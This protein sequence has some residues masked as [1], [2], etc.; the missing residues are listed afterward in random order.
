MSPEWGQV[1]PFAL[2]VDDLTIYQRGEFEY[3]VYLDP[4][5]PP[6][7]GGIGDAD[8]RSGFEQVVEW[9]GQLDPADGVMIDISPNSRGNNTLGTNDG[10]GREINPVT[11]L[12]YTQQI[13]P[14]GDY[15]RVLAEFWAD[16]PDSETPPGHWFTIA[17]YV[18]D[19][20]LVVRRFGGVGEPLDD[21]E[22]DVKLYF[23]LGGT[24]HDAAVAA[25]GAKGWYDYI[26]PISAIR[27][28]AVN[29]QSSDP[30][31]PSYHPDGIG[32]KPGVIEVVTPDTVASGERHEHLVGPGSENLGKIAIKA[33]R[34]P[35]FISDPAT[36]A[37]GVGWI[38][39]ER[40]WPYQRPTFVTPPFAGYVSGHSTFSRAAAELMT[41]FTGD[42][43]FP[44]GLGEFFAPRNEFLVFE[45]GPSVDIT[46]QW[47]TYRDASDETSIS[48]IYGGI[49]PTAD[50]IPGRLMGEQIGRNAFLL[51]T[52]YFLPGE[53]DSDGDG[54][55]DLVEEAAPNAGDN[56]QDGIADSR[57]SHVASLADQ[58]TGSYVSLVVDRPLVLTSVGTA[59]MPE[60]LPP[61]GTVFPLGLFNFSVEGLSEGSAAVVDLLLP[62]GQALETYFK[63][64]PTPA[65]ESPHWYEFLADGTTGAEIS[66]GKV[67]LRFVD[68]ERGDDDLT[69]DGRVVELGGPAQF[70]SFFFPQFADGSMFPIQFKSTLILVNTGSDSAVK[71][72]FFASPDGQPLELTLGT[73]GTDSRFEFELRRGESISLPTTGDGDLRVGYVRVTSSN[74]VSGV[75]IFSRIDQSTGVL[76]FEAGVPVATLLTEFSIAV[77]SIASKDT[78]LAIVYPAAEGAPDAI[79]TLRLFDQQFNLIAERELDPLASGSHLARF[80]HQLF[81]DEQVVSKAQEMKGLLTVESTRPLVA[82]TLRQKDAA[83]LEFPDEVPLVTAFPVVPGVPGPE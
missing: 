73:L 33:W 41:M 23:A 60:V 27:Y 72:E 45:D 7:I 21:L 46:L 35:D 24:V 55:G 20:P 14:A 18:S 47:A 1:T 68:G 31:G 4:G 34:G 57:Q 30:T 53:A 63:Y 74:D 71:T 80:V 66:E 9:S 56:N 13:V 52:R 29:G 22:W 2:G 39:A 3:W 36:T 83:G 51:A 40:W 38:L 78:G 15:Y 32:L 81:D 44:G 76:L 8:Y 42:A 19:H 75:T 79:V 54:V 48:R 10:S 50:D 67:T 77:D 62:P 17:N 49:H 28:M 6:M 59:S 12:A 25:W 64:G 5:P 11:G 43:F 61:A 82:V 37:A 65:N 70:H 58:T 26:R 16:G 69:A